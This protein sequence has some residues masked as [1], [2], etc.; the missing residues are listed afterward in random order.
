M[1]KLILIRHGESVANHLGVVAGHNDY[2]LTELG[3]E[4]AEQTAAHLANEEI[5]AVYSSDLRRA[6]ET[7]RPHA[8]L[9]GMEVI[10]SRE[11]REVFCGDWEG[12]RFDD[13]QEKDYDRFVNGFV[14]DFMR[15]TFP[16]G[17]YA[18]DCGRRLYNEVVR[19]ARKHE[20]KTVL[21]ATHGAALRAFWTI[22]CG[23]PLNVATAKHPYPSNSSYSVVNFDGERMI[24]VEYSH[25]SHM[26]V[27]THLH[28]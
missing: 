19:I 12:A 18:M 2:P 6:M 26:T 5:D 28:I 15:F 21:I 4:Q 14:K 20:E 3:F 8:K 27:V 16:N 1:T 13:L 9:R 11:L 10:P 7:A 25:D 17:E 24:P 23:T 22:I